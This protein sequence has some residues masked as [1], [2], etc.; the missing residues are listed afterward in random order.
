M[1]L[2]HAFD[3]FADSTHELHESFWDVRDRMN[4]VSRNCFGSC[5]GTLGRSFERVFELIC[6][7]Y[8]FQPC[9]SIDLINSPDEHFV[10][11]GFKHAKVGINGE[12][13]G[14]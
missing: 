6:A 1:L 4:W 3:I 12:L 11:V 5:H 2:T 10:S 7:R 13:V 9:D 8:F 14:A